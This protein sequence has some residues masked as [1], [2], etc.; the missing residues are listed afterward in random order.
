MSIYKTLFGSG[1]W[2]KT[3]SKTWKVALIVVLSGLIAYWQ[4]DIK[5]V[6]LIPVLTAL[7]DVV[8]HYPTGVKKK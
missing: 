3:L 7:L 4:G 5:Y 1:D 2:K 8:K 6:V